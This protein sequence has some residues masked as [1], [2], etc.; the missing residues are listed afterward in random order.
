MDYFKLFV[1]G[2][3]NLYFIGWLGKASDE[4]NNAI[5]YLNTFKLPT[6]ISKDEVTNAT[7]IG[8]IR[9]LNDEAGLHFG[10]FLEPVPVICQNP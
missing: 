1:I 2:D 7:S 5:S 3:G 10:S 8:A 6:Q 9:D 4:Q